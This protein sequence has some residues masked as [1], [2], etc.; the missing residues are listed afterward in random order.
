[1]CEKAGVCWAVSKYTCRHVTVCMSVLQIND[2]PKVF[3]TQGTQ[4]LIVAAGRHKEGRG[5]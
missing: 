4:V 5:C 2:I 3:V 1:M